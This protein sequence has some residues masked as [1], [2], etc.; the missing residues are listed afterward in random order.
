MSAE[1]GWSDARFDA[2]VGQEFHS[3]MSRLY[4][5]KLFRSIMDYLLERD[6]KE[7]LTEEEIARL[8][9]I[10]QSTIS[11][12][13][14]QGSLSIE[15]LVTVLTKLNRE[16][17]DLPPLPSLEARMAEGYRAAMS[18][19]SGKALTMQDF[20]GFLSLWSE[21]EWRRFVADEKPNEKRVKEKSA[22]IEKV[23]PSVA[24]TMS[25]Y[26]GRKIQ[27]VSTEYLEMLDTEWREAWSVSEKAIGYKWRIM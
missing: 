14:R 10:S 4:G 18:W 6:R 3:A 25:K 13:K 21:P 20:V 23:S 12:W 9:G 19:I 22:L 11:R 15:S 24:R 17:R 1:K 26:L 5:K 27:G 2:A 7:S 8:T 16:V